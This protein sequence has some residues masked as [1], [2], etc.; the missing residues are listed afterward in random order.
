MK[1]ICIGRNYADHAKEL[2]NNL[3]TEPLFF[4]K[5]DSAILPKGNPFFIPD[6]TQE[7][8]YEIEVVFK[9]NK[10]GKFIQPNNALRY[11]SE[12]SIGIDFTARDVQDELKK[13]GHPWEKAKGFDGSAVVPEKWIPLSEVD[14]HN[15]S[16]G[17]KKNGTWVQQG[18]T[19]NMIF[20][21]DTIIAHVSQYMTLK[22]GDLIFSGTPEGVGKIATGDVLEGF[23]QDERIFELKIK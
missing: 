13:N 6:W 3:P 1:I 20:K 22:I 10:L 18:N 16:F 2:G 8:H 23:I 14:I 15:L 5:P 19:K 17:L 4:C 21:M 9:V 7:I 12:V 11:I